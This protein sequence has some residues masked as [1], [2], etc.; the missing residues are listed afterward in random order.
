M[1]RPILVALGT[2]PRAV[3]AGV[4][5]V[6]GWSSIE[7]NP[8]LLRTVSLLQDRSAIPVALNARPQLFN[9]RR[10][11]IALFVAIQWLF[12]GMTIAISQTIAAIGFPVIIILMIPCRVYCVP[13]LFK[14]EELKVLDAQTASAPAVM[15]SL[16]TSNKHAAETGD[17]ELLAYESSKVRQVSLSTS[18]QRSKSSSSVKIRTPSASTAP[19]ESL[20][21]QSGTPPSQDT[22]PSMQSSDS[23][24]ITH[25]PVASQINS[26]ATVSRSNSTATNAGKSSFIENFQLPTRSSSQRSK[27]STTSKPSKN[28]RQ[29]D[30]ISPQ[31]ADQSQLSAIQ[32]ERERT[33]KE[34]L[35]PSFENDK[36]QAAEADQILPSAKP[37]GGRQ[38]EFPREKRKSEADDKQE[39]NP[40]KVR[41]GRD[42]NDGRNASNRRSKRIR[43]IRRQDK[44]DSSE[45]EVGTE[46]VRNENPPRGKGKG[47]PAVQAWS[48]SKR[49]FG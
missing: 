22:S 40:S 23:S 2:M 49:F 42:K 19:A 41:T 18:I 26:G 24:P 7:A 35:R 32:E 8:I 13:H 48:R 46:Y 16:G 34:S 31:S 36:P 25:F 10:R 28:L 12:F 33:L 39:K 38:A 15:C 37:F 14:P 20:R 3:F 17:S 6:V 47:V 21:R 44:D 5:L 1:T 9:L 43:T 11:T 27:V 45:D 29:S 4:F 30:E